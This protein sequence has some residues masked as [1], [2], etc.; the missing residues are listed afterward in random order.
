MH[1]GCVVGRGASSTV[2]AC[3]A[4]PTIVLKEIDMHSFVGEN[5]R[6]TAQFAEIQTLSLCTADSQCNVV[7]LRG[8]A[9]LG[10]KLWMV[11]EHCPA[12]TLADYVRQHGPLP[13]DLIQAFTKNISSAIKSINAVGKIHADVKPANFFIIENHATGVPEL[14]LG[15]LGSAISSSPT[16]CGVSHGSAFFQSPEAVVGRT[17]TKSDVYGAGAT[18]FF[19]ATGRPPMHYPENNKGKTS[20][21]CTAA[22]IQRTGMAFIT[23][24]CDV[25]LTEELA[26]FRAEQANSDL[27]DLVEAWMSFRPEDRPTP[28]STEF[29]HP[30]FLKDLIAPT[31]TTP[32]TSPAMETSPLT[33]ITEH[34]FDV[35]FS[36][37]R[38]LVF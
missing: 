16:G 31:C 5:L 3:H 37:K 33:P 19:M 27:V 36:S 23:G 6:G 20:I 35:I 8:W 7:A 25:T 2:W 15:D 18:I 26:R 28:R 14:K 38:S 29:L 9:L 30:K 11:L 10:T 4:D 12:G 34:A 1:K 21:E 32:P 24:G 17:G 13:L 22:W